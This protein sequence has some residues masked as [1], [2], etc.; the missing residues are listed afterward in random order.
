MGFL[1]DLGRHVAK[2]ADRNL[3]QKANNDYIQG[4]K[5]YRT[6]YTIS[7][8]GLFAA[9][10]F[11]VVG[12][13]QGF[14]SAGLCLFLAI[15]AIICLCSTLSLY[16]I[17]Y[18][19]KKMY[20]KVSI[21]ML[22]LLGFAAILWISIA[23][24]VYSMYVQGKAGTIG[25]PRLRMTFIQVAL[26]LSF[27]IF[28]ALL[29]TSTLIRYKKNYIVFQVIMYVSNLFVDFWFSTLFSCFN[30]TGTGKLFNLDRAAFLTK[31]GMI[32]T[33]V[34]FIVYVAICNAV[35]RSLENRRTRNLS[36]DIFEAE[37]INPVG[38]QAP[39][40]TESQIGGQPRQTE[41]EEEKLAKLKT[42]FEKNLITEEEYNKKRAE[43]IDKM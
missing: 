26:I 10:G 27:Q 24:V 30:F 4:G 43:I 8:L 36:Q 7:I 15:L 18:I 2:R 31:P 16:W 20:M 37:T 28:E 32:T 29:I 19:E 22:S 6:I 23:I 14:M 12:I 13:M 11:L 39:N 21:A 25:E 1:N 9:A 33:L 17:R 40:E 35:L 38:G 41:S 42:M 3:R 5:L 34:L